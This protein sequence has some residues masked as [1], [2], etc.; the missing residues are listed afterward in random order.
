MSVSVVLP[1]YNRE[2]TVQRAVDSVLSQTYSDLELVIV[3]DCSSDGTVNYIKSLSD[4]RIKLVKHREN[5]GASA[6]RNTGIEHSSGNF[7]SFIDSD[8]EWNPTKVEKQLDVFRSHGPEVGVVYCGTT[9]ISKNR[10]SPG[11]IPSSRGEI[12]FKQLIRDRIS[13]TS[14]VMVRQE[15]LSLVDGFDE[16]LPARQDYDLWLRLSRICEFELVP[17][18]LVNVYIDGIDRISEGLTKR[19][20]AESKLVDKYQQDIN[21][22]GIIQRK[23]ASSYRYYSIARHAFISSERLTS[24]KYCKRSI[25]IYPVNF[26]AILLLMVLFSGLDHDSFI[27]QKTRDIFRKIVD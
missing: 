2:N 16:S 20:E 24:Y 12:F 3:D 26:D 23:K 14:A 4:N 18:A 7:I 5:R 22:L 21:S 8:D 6:A 1:V 27:V 25:K 17:E 15:Y 19:I 9:N 13:P 11:V 10:S